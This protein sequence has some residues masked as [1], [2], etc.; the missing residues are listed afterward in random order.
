MNLVL[1]GFHFRQRSQVLLALVRHH[2]LLPRPHIVPGSVNEGRLVCYAYSRRCFG[3]LGPWH[4]PHFDLLWSRMEAAVGRDSCGHSRVDI[5][6]LCFSCAMMFTNNTIL[7]EVE[8]RRSLAAAFLGLFID[9]SDAGA[10][11]WNV[12]E[13][14][15]IYRRK[16][17]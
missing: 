14:R 7:L 10:S 3:R 2:T 1:R 5:P 9:D 4:C 16:I 13:A 15:S 8:R 12:T 11:D 17:T 6:S